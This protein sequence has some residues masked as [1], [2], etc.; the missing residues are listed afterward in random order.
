[1]PR[2]QKASC[3]LTVKAEPEAG[4][5]QVVFAD[6]SRRTARSML[7]PASRLGI[8]S[9]ASSISMGEGL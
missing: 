6:V 1:M 2:T 4:R 8:L 3:S 7:K 5:L 9:D